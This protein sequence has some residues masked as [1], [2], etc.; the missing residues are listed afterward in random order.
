MI[1]AQIS[2]VISTAA[3][4]LRTLTLVSLKL[5][6]ELASNLNHCL[7]LKKWLRLR[8]V[9]EPVRHQGAGSFGEITDKTQVQN[10]TMDT[11]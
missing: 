2:D 6:S 10:R 8:E 4:A 11:A 3:D 5:H 7:F 9:K 1:H